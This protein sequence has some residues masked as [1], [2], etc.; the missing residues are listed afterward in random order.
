LE[1]IK[2]VT[3]RLIEALQYFNELAS[4]N[5]IHVKRLQVQLYNT[6]G[7]LI[8]WFW[9]ILYKRTDNNLPLSVPIGPEASIW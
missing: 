4:L 1:E 6:H 8:E 7:D 3:V 9:D 2:N 5:E